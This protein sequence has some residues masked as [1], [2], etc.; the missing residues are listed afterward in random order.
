MK[1][2]KSIEDQQWY[3]L[4]G[5][6]DITTEFNMLFRRM[7]GNRVH[8]TGDIFHVIL[9]T[10]N[11][12]RVKSYFSSDVGEENINELVDNRAEKLHAQSPLSEWKSAHNVNKAYQLN[13]DPSAKIKAPNANQHTEDGEITVSPTNPHKTLTEFEKAIDKLKSSDNPR[14]LSLVIGKYHTKEEQ[15]KA[16]SISAKDFNDL[17]DDPTL[18]DK[19]SGGMRRLL[20][21][22]R[23]E[24]YCYGMPKY[25]FRPIEL[26]A[27]KAVVGQNNL[28]IGKY[29]SLARNSK[30]VSIAK[31]DP[32][33]AIS[34]I[35]YQKL[36]PEI[37]YRTAVNPFSD[38][39]GKSSIV[40]VG[41][42]VNSVLGA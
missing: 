20:K 38:S 2:S 42:D 24:R 33:T 36:P 41:S 9:T 11:T 3:Q 18:V 35:V 25:I 15:N 39:N 34:A 14:L 40:L 4:Y 30:D 26:S 6:T 8:E 21:Y 29:Q 17:P 27:D 22:G 23:C 19:I 32:E 10:D 7:N 5:V 28:A 16:A 31:C 37:V 12:R 13:Y 1:W